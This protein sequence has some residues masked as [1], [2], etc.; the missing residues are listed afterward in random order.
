[1][2]IL[3]T[4]M[5]EV[6]LSSETSVLTTAAWHDILEDRILHS[7]TMKTSNLATILMFV[8]SMKIGAPQMCSVSTNKKY[9]STCQTII[10][11]NVYHM[12]S[13]QFY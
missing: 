4:L 10:T 8:H 12:N 11:Q 7:H 1:L 5:M 3:V 2:L 6:M 13:S 9:F